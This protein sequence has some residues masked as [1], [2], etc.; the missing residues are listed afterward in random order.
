MVEST[1]KENTQDSVISQVVHLDSETSYKIKPRALIF[2]ANEKDLDKIK[3]LIETQFPKVEIVYI[4][5]GPA[6]SILRVTKSMHSETQNY[7]TQPL[8][9][10]E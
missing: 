6:T 1:L 9:T 10:I 5:T 2:K 7:L 3:E 8:Y 4:T